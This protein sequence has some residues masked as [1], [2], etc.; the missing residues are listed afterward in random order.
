MLLTVCMIRNPSKHCTTTRIVETAGWNG[1]Q[2]IGGLLLQTTQQT[3]T[4]DCNGRFSKF[5]TACTFDGVVYDEAT[6]EVVI[7]PASSGGLEPYG[8]DAVFLESS[9]VYDSS[10]SVGELDRSTAHFC[11]LVTQVGVVTTVPCC[12]TSINDATP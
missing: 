11:N 9:S 10:L 4:Q 8:V 1:N 6:G 3:V 2:V 12:S 5:K 7:Q